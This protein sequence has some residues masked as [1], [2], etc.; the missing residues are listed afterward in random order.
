MF[1]ADCKPVKQVLCRHGSLAVPELSSVYV[2][3]SGHFADILVD[4]WETQQ[5]W[6]GHANIIELQ[7]T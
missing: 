1:V 4:G 5:V 3:M 2:K 7:I 6:G